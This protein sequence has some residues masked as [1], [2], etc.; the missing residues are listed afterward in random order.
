[1]TYSGYHGGDGSE[2][3]RYQANPAFTGPATYIP[4]TYD[5][6]QFYSINTG[7]AVTSSYTVENQVYI[8]KHGDGI[9]YSK[10]QITGFEIAS[11][12]HTYS[13]KVKTF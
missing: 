3:N 7:V 2:T 8:I 12:K 4:Y 11:S 5:K 6:K 1:M 13:L 10:I 9:K